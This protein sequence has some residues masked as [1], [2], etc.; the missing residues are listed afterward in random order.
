MRVSFLVAIGTSDCVSWCYYIEA[1]SF[2]IVRMV[3]LAKG[4]FIV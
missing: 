3:Y 2:H 1:C 4:S